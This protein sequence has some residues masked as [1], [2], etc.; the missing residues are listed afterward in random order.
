MPQADQTSPNQCASKLSIYCCFNG[1]TYS[2]VE[3]PLETQLDINNDNDHR[4]DHTII[5]Q[6]SGDNVTK[7]SLV[8]NLEKLLVD[9]ATREP[10][11]VD[12]VYIYS[13]GMTRNVNCITQYGS[14]STQAVPVSRNTSIAEI[15]KLLNNYNCQDNHMTEGEFI[16]SIKNNLMCSISFTRMKTPGTSLTLSVEHI[17][18]ATYDKLDTKN[19][20]PFTNKIYD[21]PIGFIGDK[22]LQNINALEELKETTANDEAVSHA[23]IEDSDSDIVN[24]MRRVLCTTPEPSLACVVTGTRNSLAGASLCGLFLSYFACLSSTAKQC[25]SNHHWCAVSI[26]KHVL[27]FL[28]SKGISGCLAKFLSDS[29]V[30]MI[31]Y[32]AIGVMIG[33][34]A[35]GCCVVR[36]CNQSCVNSDRVRT[37]EAQRALPTR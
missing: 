26:Y 29:V 31:P 37:I 25:A 32:A 17:D 4:S 28:N 20:D 23:G 19:K 11:Q 22:L 13:D 16:E 5:N 36:S 8:V 27:G 21:V 18:K 7:S 3:P 1:N 12:T 33:A 24:L 30:G 6:P 35:T 9:P 2:H 14:S 34:C 15:I 10:L